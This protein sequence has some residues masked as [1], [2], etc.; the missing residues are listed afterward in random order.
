MTRLFIGI[1][2]A[3][4]FTIGLWG[5]QWFLEEEFNNLDNWDEL[6][7]PKIENQSHYSASREGEITFLRG[8]SEASASGLI[9]K[10]EFN[11]ND[12]THLSWRWRIKTTIPGAKDIKKSGDDY[13]IRI[14]VIF[15]YDPDSSEG[16]MKLKYSL[17][18]A[19]YGEYPPHSALNYVWANVDWDTEWIPNPFTDRAVMIAM[20]R[21]NQLT[22]EWRV[23]SSNI[24][25]TYRKVFGED[26]PAKASLAIMSDSDN[27]GE[28]GLG[29]IDYIRIGKQPY[30]R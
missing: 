23:H 22:G 15:E 30:V 4:I 13:A 14:Y 18:K 27:T 12:W 29:D 1:L 3:F 28:A 6:I 20:D 26:P 16:F 17:A 21:G 11:V 2:I 10:G 24:L 9:Y 8:E 7:F 19:L 5:D 25:E